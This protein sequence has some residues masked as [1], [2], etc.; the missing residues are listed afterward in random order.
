MKGTSHFTR[1]AMLIPLV[2]KMMLGHAWT[3]F[4]NKTSKAVFGAL[5]LTHFQLDVVI[6]VLGSICKFQDLRWHFQPPAST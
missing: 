2:F 3:V 6:L 4:K 1:I 5:V